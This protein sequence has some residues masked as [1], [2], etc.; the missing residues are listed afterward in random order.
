MPRINSSK[1]MVQA[2]WEHV[3]HIDEQTQAELLENT[4]PHLRDARSKGTPSLGAGAIY[5][6]EQSEFMVDPFPIPAHFAKGY[7]FDVGWNRTAAIFGAWDR[8]NDVT[9]LYTEHYRGQAEPSVHAEA[10]RARGDWL[11][12][13]IDP[14]SRGRSQKDGEQLLYNYRELGLNLQIANNAVEAGILEVLQLLSTGRLKVFRTCQNWLN[15]HRI[16]RRDEKG[17][18]VKAFD[19]LMDATRYLVLARANIMRTKP[20]IQRPVEGFAVADRNGGY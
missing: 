18:I 11:I 17:R 5:P 13:A 3:P 7:G 2:G 12:G 9:Y 16:Y 15:E 1:Y 14:A 8:D 6:I 10:I 4:P 20:A 19:H